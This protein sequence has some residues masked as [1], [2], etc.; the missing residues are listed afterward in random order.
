MGAEHPAMVAARSSWSCVQRRAKE[1]WLEL[2]AEDVVIED[3]IGVSPLDPA[4]QG[5]R[6]KPAARAF[7][8]RNVAATESI[9]IEA[10]ESFAAGSESAHVL[11]LTT[12]FP[13]GVR[14]TVHGIFT[15]AVDGAGKLRALRGYW[16]LDQAVVS[17][18]A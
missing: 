9:A 18:P 4:G 3:P 13:N 2:M 7:W 8:D 15:Y 1:E 6:G 16:Q 11:T 17:K 10:H 12:R 14:M 5:L